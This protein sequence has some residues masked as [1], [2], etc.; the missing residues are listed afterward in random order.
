DSLDDGRAALIQWARLHS[1]AGDA[2]ST[3]R[4]IVLADD[5]TGTWRLWQLVR[6]D[7]SL[8][9]DVDSALH[10]TAERDA[11]LAELRRIAEQ[12]I[13]ADTRLA[14]LSIRLPATL[15]NLAH[16]DAGVVYIGFM[17]PVA[18]PL[19]EPRPRRDPRTILRGS[20]EPL[21]ARDLRDREIELD[22]L[23]GHAP[24]PS[25]PLPTIPAPKP[26]AE[27]PAIRESGPHHAR[28]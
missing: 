11:T 15:D 21:I 9:D 5:G 16:T 24:R 23:L 1:T 10:D 20:L 27:A 13:D 4:C 19:T 14:A 25:T 22:E 3:A 28:G 6:A 2:L 26:A 17:P 7:P 18:T 8:R 12:L